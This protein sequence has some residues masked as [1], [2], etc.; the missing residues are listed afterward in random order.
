MQLSR[1]HVACT[2]HQ[3]F[4]LAECLD[5]LRH[6]R[7]HRLGI[8]HVEG[9]GYRLATVGADFVDQLG[10]LVHAAGPQ[11]DRKPAAGEFGCGGRAD[12]RRC[13]GDDGGPPGGVRFEAW[14]YL[15][16]TLIGRWANPRTLLEWTRT[17][18]SSSTS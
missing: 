2:G 1:E 11:G 17:T 14:H 5:R 12:A 8:G 4:D 18:L 10:Q 3:Q 15:A 13:A 9:E 7:F 16:C 6:K